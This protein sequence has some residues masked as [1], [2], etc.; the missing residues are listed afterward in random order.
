MATIIFLILGGLLTEPWVS[1]KGG[2]FT[3]RTNQ[4]LLVGRWRGNTGVEE[5]D[6]QVTGCKIDSDVLYDTGKGVNIL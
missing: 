6:A 2:S 1:Q 4:W 3:D 5:G